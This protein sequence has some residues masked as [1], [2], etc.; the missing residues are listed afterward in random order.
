MN[1]TKVFSFQAHWA[2]FDLRIFS[3]TAAP[4][5]HSETSKSFSEE[6]K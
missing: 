6:T 2:F 1:K 5:D 3:E 4:L